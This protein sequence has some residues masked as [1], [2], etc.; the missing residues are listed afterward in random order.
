MFEVPSV[1]VLRRT[2]TMARIRRRTKVMRSW[3]L[4]GHG[5]HQRP[6]LTV[7]YCPRCGALD[8]EDDHDTP[9]IC[10]ECWFTEPDPD[11]DP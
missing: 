3:C 8:G 5:S 2:K 7:A 6:V 4:L 10:D 1:V 9:F 11:V